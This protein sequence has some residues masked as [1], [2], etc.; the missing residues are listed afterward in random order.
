MTPALPI[1][2]GRDLV[3][4]LCRAGQSIRDRKGGHIHL[5]HPFRRPPTV[6]DH[7]EVARGTLRVILKDAGLTADELPELP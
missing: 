2:S 3:R 4:A 1:L 6:P 5:R 7:P